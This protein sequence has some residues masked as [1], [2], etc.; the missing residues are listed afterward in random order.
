MKNKVL[1]FLGLCLTLAA[2]VLPATRSYANVDQQAAFYGQLAVSGVHLGGAVAGTGQGAAVST[3]TTVMELYY[4]GTSSAA[5]VG[6]TTGGSGT[7][8]DCMTF[9]TAG[10]V[11]DTSIGYATCGQ[12]GGTFDLGVSSEGLTLGSLCDLINNQPPTIGTNGSANGGS[13][14]ASNY[15]CMLTD[16]IRSDISSQL[17]PTITVTQSVNN[18]NQ[19]GGYTIPVGTA[20]VMSLGIIPASGRRVV[21]DYISVNAAGTPSVYVYGAKAKFGVGAAGLDTFGNPQTDSS[22]AWVSPA[23]AANTTTNFPLATPIALPWL[24]FGQGG[25]AFTYKNPPVGN[26][27]N[28]HVV[29]RVSNYAAAGAAMTSSNFLE[30]SWTEK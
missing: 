30:V 9:Y 14:T 24:E 20:T 5:N 2:S 7:N 1:K 29:I 21:L 11:I 28:G 26:F 6:I 15:H 10:A 23:L 22:L 12:T 17:L 18:L 13:P 19:V 4:T 3:T 16:A 25:V 8:N 27:Y